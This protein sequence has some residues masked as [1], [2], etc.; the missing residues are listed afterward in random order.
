[1]RA[2]LERQRHPKLFTVPASSCTGRV[3][4]GDLYFSDMPALQVLHIIFN[5]KIKP[6][7]NKENICCVAKRWAHSLKQ[8][9]DKVTEKTASI[10][11]PG[12]DKTPGK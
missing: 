12:E 4:G 10:A 8:G 1:M 11:K 2:C 3:L 7:N 5:F 9:S 6:I